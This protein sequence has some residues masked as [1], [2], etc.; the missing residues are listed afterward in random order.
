MF[1]YLKYIIFLKLAGIV[2]EPQ[3]YA[4]LLRYEKLTFRL[5]KR[6]CLPNNKT[7]DK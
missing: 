5:C 7:V 4:L 1:D 6:V 2:K 3:Q